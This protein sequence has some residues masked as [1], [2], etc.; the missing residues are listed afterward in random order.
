VATLLLVSAAGALAGLVLAHVPSCTT[1]AAD[2][3]GRRQSCC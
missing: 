1:A 3:P 2:R